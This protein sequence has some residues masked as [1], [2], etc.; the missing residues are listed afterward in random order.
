MIHVL[1]RLVERYRLFSV[2][3]IAE[4]TRLRFCRAVPALFASAPEV[5]ALSR[6]YRSQSWPCVFNL[7]NCMYLY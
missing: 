6:E 2:E 4:T 1:K 7:M 3:Q 5:Q